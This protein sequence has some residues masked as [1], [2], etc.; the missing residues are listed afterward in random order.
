MVTLVVRAQANAR[1]N[2]TLIPTLTPC[3]GRGGRIACAI[4]LIPPPRGIKFGRSQTSKKWSNASDF[5]RISGGRIT[6]LAIISCHDIR[7]G[8]RTRNI[9]ISRC[10]MCH[11]PCAMC[12]V[13]CAMCRR[14][15]RAAS[16]VPRGTISTPLNC[17]S[18]DCSTWNISPPRF[19]RCVCPSPPVVLPWR[20]S[21]LD[22]SWDGS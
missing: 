17:F 6:F 20:F 19:R 2:E 5:G 9:N 12:H 3:K 11:V 22:K 8:T 14:P 1:L 4:F 7:S 13:P 10:A 18:T 16:I 21:P 15:V